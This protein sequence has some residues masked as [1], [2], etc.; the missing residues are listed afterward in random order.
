MD[1]P[2][3]AATSALLRHSRIPSVRPFAEDRGQNYWG[4]A[5]ERR[6]GGRAKGALQP[7]K[8]SKGEGRA[9][10]GVKRERR[11]R[12]P[13]AGQY[14]SETALRGRQLPHVGG[15][16]NERQHS[17]GESRKQTSAAAVQSTRLV[18]TWCHLC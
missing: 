8:A 15:G 2:G 17:K 3:P 13:S 18:A 12:Y 5:R 6:R 11:E 10:V 9:A 1:E 4:P 16:N 7:R 14:C